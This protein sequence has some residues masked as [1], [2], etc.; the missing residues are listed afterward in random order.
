MLSISF[1]RYDATAF[2]SVKLYF[3]IYDLVYVEIYNIVAYLVCCLK[4]V[5]LYRNYY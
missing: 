4:S 1:Y 5:L 2:L 3:K